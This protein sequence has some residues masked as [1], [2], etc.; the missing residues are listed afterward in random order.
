MYTDAERR[1]T[2]ADARATLAR[3]AALKQP[4]PELV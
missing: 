4:E 3:T 1:E 2:L